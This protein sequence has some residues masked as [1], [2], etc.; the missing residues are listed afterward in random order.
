MFVPSIILELTLY[1][2]CFCLSSL[3]E[4]IK[5]RDILGKGMSVRL[6]PCELLEGVS[7][8]QFLMH[9]CVVI[10]FCFKVQSREFV[11]PA[12]QSFLGDM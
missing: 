1:I 2:N 9:F 10:K 5:G 12:F 3:L 11:M 8:S 6:F 7:P 4:V